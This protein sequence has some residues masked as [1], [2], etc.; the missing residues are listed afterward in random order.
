MNYTADLKN[1]LKKI[2]LLIADVDGVLTD[3]SIYTGANGMEFKRFSVEDGAG[4][5]IARS[6][7]IRLALISGRY[8]AATEARARELRIEDVYNGTLNKLLPYQELLARYN[9]RDEEVA[10]IG[11]GLIDLVILERVGVPISVNN[12][13]PMVKNASVYVTK[14]NG[15]SGALREAVDWILKGQDRYEAVLGKLRQ[16]LLETPNP[17]NG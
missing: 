17:D 15:G 3:G 14:T 9:L 6:A 7:G 13:Y 2:K 10:F 4:V 12:G 16:E 1:K 5:A 8:S 11:D